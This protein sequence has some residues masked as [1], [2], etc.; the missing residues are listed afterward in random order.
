MALAGS[1]RQRTEKEQDAFDKLLN[2]L[3]K[4]LENNCD[5]TENKLKEKVHGVKSRHNKR[6]KRRR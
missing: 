3:P 5:G 6:T 2:S 1:M 4:S